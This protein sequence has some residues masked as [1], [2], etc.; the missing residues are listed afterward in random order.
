M[1]KYII[2]IEAEAEFEANSPHEAYEM[3]IESSAEKKVESIDRAEVWEKD[4]LYSETG[5]YEPEEEHDLA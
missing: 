5:D 2:R 4:K 1:T 3:W